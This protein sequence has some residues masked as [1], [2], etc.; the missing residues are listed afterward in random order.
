MSYNA[1]D[2]A[3]AGAGDQSGRGFKVGIFA[4]LLPAVVTASLVYYVVSHTAPAGAVSATSMPAA[5]AQRIAKVGTVEIRDNSTRVQHTGEEVFKRTCTACHTSGA[6]GSP[7]FG[8]AAAWAP[9]IA[10]GFEALLHSALK[11]KNNMMAQGGGEYDDNE[12]ARAVVYMANAGGA[13]FVEP[14]SPAAA[15]SAPVAAK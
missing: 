7:K 9:R 14:K 13:K 15:A 10:T 6:L 5:V 11:G 12:V 3:D 1:H 2:G 8:D 4:L